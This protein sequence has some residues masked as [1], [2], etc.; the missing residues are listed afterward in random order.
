MVSIALTAI[1]S[2]FIKNI[3]ILKYIGVAVVVLVLLYL[4]YDYSNTK[5]ENQL[6]EIKL[7]EKDVVIKKQNQEHTKELIIVSNIV[8]EQERQRL[9]LENYIV[10]L[11]KQKEVKSNV[12]KNENFSNRNIVE[13]NF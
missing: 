8:R 2:F 11:K 1:R 5:A 4:G 9:E 10:E 13:F 6:L 7:K 3:S 12:K